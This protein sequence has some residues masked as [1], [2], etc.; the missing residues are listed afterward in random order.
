MSGPAILRLSSYAARELSSHNYQMPLSVN[1]ISMKETD[2][3]NE[4]NEIIVRN[5]QKQIGSVRPFNLPSR[6]WLYLASKCLGE[7]V[8]YRWKEITQK[9]LNRLTNLIINNQYQID[10]RASFKDEFV[11]CGG[12]SLQAV[13]N[14]TL[15]SKSHPGLYFAGEVL[16]IDGVTGGF[17]FQAAWTTAYAVAHSISQ[18]IT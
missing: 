8:R 11:T 15:E 9:E 4:L 2:V 18:K 5:Q 6:L 3:M 10:G 16:D 7:R 14:N 13:D 12:I 1:W 17:N